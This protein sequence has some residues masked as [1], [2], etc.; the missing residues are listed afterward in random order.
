MAVAGQF[1][2]MK[3]GIIGSGNVGGTLTRRLQALGHEVTVGNSRGPETLTPLV[4]ET[5]ATPGTARQAA[6]SGDVVVIAT[7][8]RAVPD[9]PA[10]ALRG[11]VVVDASNYYPRRDGQI[12]P[13]DG[14]EASSR[15]TSEHLPGAA[16]VKA[17][18]TI[19][20]GHLLA[21]GLPAGDPTRIALP[22][23]SDDPSAKRTVMSLVEELGFDPID[24]GGLDDSWRQQPGSPV[25][26]TDRDAAGVR[27][28][29]SEARR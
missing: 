14:G 2:G 1:S 9:L 15:W 27:D 6:E 19:Q 4:A 23:A 16:V 17:F 28:G 26:T 13:I 12:G 18:N 24:A 5:G 10:D 20:A 3:I 8:V 25:Y 7:P 21:G 29:L 11:K 22:V